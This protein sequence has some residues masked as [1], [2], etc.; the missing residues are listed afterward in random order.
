MSQMQ[1]VR[2][3]IVTIGILLPGTTLVPSAASA[4]S[5]MTTST[6]SSAWAGYV[7]YPKKGDTIRE[8]QASFTVP[9]VKCARSVGPRS[10]S[11]I[12][13]DGHRWLESRRDGYG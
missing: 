11:L 1:L 9:E 4:T 7:G 6:S 12:D 13:V 10:V 2:A 3:S 8:V 5:P